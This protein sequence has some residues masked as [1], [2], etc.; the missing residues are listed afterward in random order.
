MAHTLNRLTPRRV[1]TAK[2]P[3]LYADGGGLYLRVGRGGAKSWCLRYMLD[4][5]AREMGLGGLS[6]IGLADARKKASAQR[7]LLVER[8]DPLARRK[9][10]RTAKRIEAARAMTFDDCAAAYIKAHE[11]GWRNAKH[12]Q[13]WANTLTTYVT[14]VFGKV[15]VG[16]VN[17]AMVMNVVEPLWSTKPET[18]GRVRGRIEAVLDW[19]KAR[20]HRNGEN[21]A[22][23]RGHLSNLLPARSKVRAVKHHAALPYTEIGSFMVD[24]RAR[25][26]T[27]A[28]ALQFL[29]LTAARTNEVIGARWSEVDVGARMWTVPASRMKG[30]LEHRVPLTSAA[31]AVLEPMLPHGGVFLFPSA[32]AERALS[33]MALLKMLEHMCRGDLT[34]HGFRAT[35]K[36]WASE[37]TNFPREI[38][39]AALAHVLGDK[40][41]AAYQRGDLFDKRRR[42]MDAWAE[43]CAKPATGGTVVN[44]RQA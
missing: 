19:A 11:A 17:V 4:G 40:V 43:F 27:A 6:K 16:D 33:N 5:K 24:L 12:R 39:E 29:I 15:P 23:W 34:A 10:E 3:G 28:S 7:L 14:P 41:E 38:V 1:E 25:E 42:L 13:Q 31:L 18:A 20:E 2:L 37:R 21:P 36:T 32:K 8:V 35:F 30:Q 44:L 9:A 26:S 22:R